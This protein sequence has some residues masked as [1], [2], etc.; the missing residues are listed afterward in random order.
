MD[1]REK[2]FYSNRPFYLDVA[3]LISLHL[4]KTAGSSFLASLRGFY[5]ESLLLDYADFPIN[6]PVFKRNRYALKMFVIN[7]IKH[8]KNVEAIHGHF[9]PLKYLLCRDAKFVTW[10]REPIERLASHYFYW[11]RSYGL[12][13]APL[14]HK[15]VV[16]EQWSFERFCLAPELRNFYSQFFWG[17]PFRRFD[18]IGITEHYETELEY[19]SNEFL[20]ATLQ[21]R[22]ENENPN[23]EKAS[24]FEDKNLR[25]KVERYH[26]RDVALYKRALD[27]RRTTRCN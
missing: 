20:G 14:L 4:P 1:F 15:R 3:V 18:F 6:T 19:F 7:G 27:L 23:H 5:G 21:V 8:H 10:M 2:C 11:L 16:E 24:Y 17:F 9:L 12:Q 25:E 26:S 22:R 13:N